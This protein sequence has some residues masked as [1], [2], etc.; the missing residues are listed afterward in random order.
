M[1]LRPTWKF[2]IMVTCSMWS[3]IPW[4]RTV[5]QASSKL[6]GK[7]LSKT[8]FL[9]ISFLSVRQ[10]GFCLNVFQVAC[11]SKDVL[12][13]IFWG[14]HLYESDCWSQSM[15]FGWSLNTHERHWSMT[16]M[17]QIK[18]VSF[19]AQYQLRTLV[20]FISH[21]TVNSRLSSLFS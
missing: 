4:S 9:C 3:E 20:T 5:K 15:R 13:T 12:Q 1:G 18:G 16:Y 10:A 19:A 21:K 8:H 11:Q 6:W 14:T 2:T 7:I 17:L